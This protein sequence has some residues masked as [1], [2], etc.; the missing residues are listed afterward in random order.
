MHYRELGRTGLKVSLIGLGTMTWGEQNSEADAHAQLD[1]ALSLGVNL[2]DAAEM[3]PVPPRAE[4]CGRTESFIGSW[5]KKTGRRHDIVLATKAAG[6]AS[7]PKRPQHVRGGR[8]HFTK[9]NLFE[10]VD[11]SLQRLQTDHIDLYQLH[12]PDRRTSTF[13]QPYRHAP[14]PQD[15]PIEETL[16]ALAAL[17]QSGKVR[18]VG[19]SNETPWGLHRYLH[20]ADRGLGPRIASIQN[21][22]NLLNRSFEVGLAEFSLRERVP[23][24]A[25]SP[26]AMGVLSGKYLDGARPAGA[27]L[28]R[29][30]RFDRYTKPEATEAAAQYVA[31]F[32]RHGIDPAQGALAW[33]NGRDFVA[34]NLI[35]ATT[36]EQLKAD[37][38]SVDLV[39]P[40]EVV[41]GI[42]ALRRRYG[43][44]AP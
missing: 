36:L 44:P 39:L 6:P 5:L 23:L 34:S 22:Y 40:A 13:G 41:E 25:Y 38:A 31:L 30:D 12:W 9:A 7:D 10:A 11:D 16:E 20:G 3:Y 14:A 1:L 24:L 28:T 27:R 29:F 35:G 19:V 18:Q 4:T 2:V 26:L 17:V 15:T 32:R 8:T 43:D 37:I 21:P 42:E 33:V